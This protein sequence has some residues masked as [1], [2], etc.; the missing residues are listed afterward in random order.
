MQSWE[1]TLQEMS[2]LNAKDRKRY[3]VAADLIASDYARDWTRGYE[4]FKEMG[5]KEEETRKGHRA[6][7]KMI[8]PNF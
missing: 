4:L 1:L 6:Y 3:I 8:K 7:I 5:W 2:K